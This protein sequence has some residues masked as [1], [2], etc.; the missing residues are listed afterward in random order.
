[1]FCDYC[2]RP[3][4]NLRAIQTH[5]QRMHPSAT[6]PHGNFI[7]ITEIVRKTKATAEEVGGL[8]QLKELVEELSLI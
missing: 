1:M 3:F 2:N 4:K 7:S 8:T 5:Y 6:I